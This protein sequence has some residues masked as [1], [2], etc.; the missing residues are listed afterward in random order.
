MEGGKL[1]A[2]GVWRRRPQDA[3]ILWHLESCSSNL[4]GCQEIIDIDELFIVGRAGAT[5]PI[6]WAFG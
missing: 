3:Q 1:K 2:I 6:I 4:G 5:R